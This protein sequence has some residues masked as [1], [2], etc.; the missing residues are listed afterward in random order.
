MQKTRTRGLRIPGSSARTR[1]HSR[2]TLA[3]QD[4]LLGY[5]TSYS[6]A[7]PLETPESTSQPVEFRDVLTGSQQRV[8]RGF[9]ALN[10]LVTI[11]FLCWLILPTHIPARPDSF[12]DI[13]LIAGVVAF[14]LLVLLEVVRLSQSMVLCLFSS[15]MKDPV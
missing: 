14:A 12:R 7:G 13:G 11:I 15:K 4:P 10:A 9:L 5:R 8:L 1:S 3:V 2:T 6:I